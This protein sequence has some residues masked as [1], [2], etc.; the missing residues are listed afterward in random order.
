MKKLV[1][2]S[3]QIINMSENIDK[4]LLK[5]IGK[6]NPKVGYIASYTDT[7]RVWFYRNKEYYAKMGIN[8]FSYFDVDKEFDETKVEDLLSSDAIH[9]SGGNTFYF[10]SLFK[11][12]K[13]IELIKD[14]VYRGGV[15]IGVSAGSIIMTPKIDIAGFIDENEIEL[16]E[17]EGLE[18]V[19]FE[20]MPHW[21][22]ENNIDNIIDY[23]RN[24]NSTV[25]I[26]SDRDG[27]IIDNDEIK[28]I[29][30]VIKISDGKIL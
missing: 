6:E 1:L 26:C 19:E 30:D 16:T 27:I 17:T 9:L 23:S 12:R 5:L 11:K 8:N 24:N 7:D 3:D 10:L 13:F 4:E 2:Y 25:Y 18:L 15:L 22:K 20:Y 29:G 14:Y 21:Q 28:F